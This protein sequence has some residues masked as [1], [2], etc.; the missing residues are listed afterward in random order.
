MGE[1]A[2]QIIELLL[3]GADLGLKVPLAIVFGPKRRFWADSLI[4]G[5]KSSLQFPQGE[6]QRGFGSGG[7]LWGCG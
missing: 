7:M 4:C 6:G 3:G 5:G 2:A 1:P